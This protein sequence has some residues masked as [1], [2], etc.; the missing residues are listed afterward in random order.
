LLPVPAFRDTTVLPGHQYFY[1]VRAIDRAGN[2]SGL[3]A[4]VAVQIPAP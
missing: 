3:S 1:R 4:P 2:E